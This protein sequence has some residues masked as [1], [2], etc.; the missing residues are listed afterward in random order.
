MRNEQH[1]TEKQINNR[2]N[3][4]PQIDKLFRTTNHNGAS[5]R[6]TYECN[7]RQFYY[8]V[9]DNYGIQS[10]AN[11]KAKHLVDYVEYMQG[12]DLAPATII[13]RIS[14]IRF[15]HNLSGSKNM[16]L[17]NSK[18]SLDKRTNGTVNRGWI[19]PTDIEGCKAE[20]TKQGKFYICD[21]VDIGVNFGLRISEACSLRVEDIKKAIFVGEL[22]IRS[23]K[24]G[25][26]RYIP[27]DLEGQRKVLVDLVAKCEKKGMQPSEFVISESRKYGPAETEKRLEHW[28]RNHR[29]KFTTPDRDKIV[30]KGYKPYTK[31][32]TWHG[33]R[34]TY[35]QWCYNYYKAQGFD[36][37][38][39][40]SRNLGHNR[41]S[42]TRMYLAMNLPRK[43]KCK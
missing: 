17:D 37:E 8:Y 10:I 25:R 6:H 9:S 7:V 28:L 12:H 27:I 4:D 14:A 23:G 29:H 30:K 42:T 19:Y 3:I 40:V 18:L 39:K 33:L 15:A 34:Y 16:L 13:S 26:P 32:L 1:L 5:T 20:A 43:R 36:A 35:A 24:G 21:F 11:V 31:E 38:A 22:H 2:R 41:R